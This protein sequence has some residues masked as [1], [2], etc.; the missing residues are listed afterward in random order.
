MNEV[1]TAWSVLC[2]EEVEQGEHH[3]VTA[4]HVV[5]T[6]VHSRQGHPKTA[7]DG[8]GSLQFGPHVAVDLSGAL[9]VLPGHGKRGD[10]HGDAAQHEDG[11]HKA[12]HAP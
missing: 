1:P 3:R 8:D 2:D 12:A 4:E 10:K 5:A 7:P 9:Q 11:P 6:R